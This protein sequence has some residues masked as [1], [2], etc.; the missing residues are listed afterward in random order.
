LQVSL[1]ELHTVI[2]PHH[3]LMLQRADAVEVASGIGDKGRALAGDGHRPGPVVERQPGVAQEPI[4][5]LH[6]G[7]PGQAQLLR[8]PTL[9][10][11]PQPFHAAP[12]LRRM[13]G[14][15]LD[16]ELREGPSDLGGRRDLLGPMGALARPRRHEVAGLVHVEGAEDAQL[17]EDR[18]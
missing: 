8:Q 4:G 18:L 2:V 11:F 3:A 16:T 14:D 17:F 15:Q 10:G 12:G 5:G 6:R 9:P 1:V 13:R 7:D